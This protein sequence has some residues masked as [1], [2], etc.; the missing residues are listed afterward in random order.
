M[1]TD[2]PKTVNEALKI[3]AYNE[4]FWVNSTHPKSTQIK[5]HGKDLETVRSLAESQYAWTEKQAK[6][7]VVILKRY[8][9]KF[10]K[11]EMDIRELLESPKFD[12]PFRVISFDKS[13]EKFIDEDEVAKIELRF[14]YNKKIITLIRILKD[15]RGLPPGYAQY[16]GDS[17]KWIFLQTDVTTYYLT[18]LAIRYDF[19]FIDKSLLDDYYSVKEE[20]MPYKTPYASLTD[21]KIIIN[22]APESLQDYWNKNI[23]PLPLIQQVDSLKEFGISANTIKVNSITELGGK[24][25]HCDKTKIWISRNKHGRDNIMSALTELNAFPIVM[26]VS[27][28]PSSQDDADEWDHW[29]QCFSRHGITEKNLSFGFDIKEPKRASDSTEY[30]DNIV[31]KMTDDRYQTLYEVYQLSK[32]FKFI[33]DNTMVIFVRNR[34]PRSLIKSKIKPKCLLVALGGG[35]Y[36]SGTDNLKRFLDSLPKTLYYNDHEPTLFYAG[37]D[38]L[39]K[40]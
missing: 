37:E 36:A 4:Y 34:I 38:H 27:G 17:K 5:P 20:I 19:K 24:I 3:L 12:E 39:G 8:L 28:D 1:H 7:A 6:L 32:Q 11:Y 10:Q 40:I 9:T 30:T 35:Y 26:N 33:D 31:G 13:I 21:N 16:D 23:L 25:A 18:L 14:P 22:H 29:L 2:L 15:K